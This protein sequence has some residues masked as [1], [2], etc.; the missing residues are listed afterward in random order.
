[1]LSQCLFPSHWVY[2]NQAGD[3]L[4]NI[5]FA[6]QPMLLS[7]DTNLKQLPGMH[8]LKFGRTQLKQSQHNP[9]GLSIG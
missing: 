9:G 7:A 3:G 1:M 4:Y 2:K 5:V 6:R 8:Q